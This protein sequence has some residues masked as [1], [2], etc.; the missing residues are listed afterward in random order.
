MN[1]PRINSRG[2]SLV[3]ML[4]LIGVISILLVL[5]LTQF[6]ALIERSRSA[7]CTQHLRQIGSLFH[8]YTAENPGIVRLFRDGSQNGHLRWY[9]LLKETAG[10][11]KEEA[12][13]AFGCPSLPAKDVGD[14]FCYG[15]RAGGLP[16]VRVTGGLYELS[17]HAVEQPSRFFLAGDTMAISNAKQ[18]FRIIPPGLFNNDAGIHLRHRGYANM[19]FLDG[20]VEAMNFEMLADVGIEEALG[21]EKE[22][23]KT[24]K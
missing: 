1:K 11:G 14:W 18:T 20:H 19:L 15:F 22:R 10:M 4:V 23:L 12:Q 6:G 21:P 5:C 16:G 7:E 3:E 17:I 24:S 13:R 2:I 9:N 8:T